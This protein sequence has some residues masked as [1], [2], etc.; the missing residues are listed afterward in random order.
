[1]NTGDNGEMNQEQV[2]GKIE[3]VE[4]INNHGKKIT[5]QSCLHD[6]CPECR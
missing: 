2:I 4:L 6:S 1:M 5:G 3:I